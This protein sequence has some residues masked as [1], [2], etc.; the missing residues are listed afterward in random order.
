[1]HLHGQPCA[2]GSDFA[3]ATFLYNKNAY[4]LAI[5]LPEN[6]FKTEKFSSLYQPV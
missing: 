1:M 3:E 2:P 6:L 5:L 4:R